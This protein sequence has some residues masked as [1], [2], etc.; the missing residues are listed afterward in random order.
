M[1]P[2]RVPLQSKLKKRRLRPT[3]FAAIVKR[4]VGL[5]VALMDGGGASGGLGAGLFA[6]WGAKLHARFDVI[7]E[8]LGL[9]SALQKA[10]MILTAEGAVDFQNSSRQGSRSLGR[11]R[12]QTRYS[13]HWLGWNDWK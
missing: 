12:S 9:E 13:S 4:D 5:D 1:D 2:K 8:Y 10:D 6:F 3:T 11:T 7:M